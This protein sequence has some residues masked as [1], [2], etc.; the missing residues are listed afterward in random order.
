MPPSEATRLGEPTERTER[1][2]RLDAELAGLDALELARTARRPLPARLWSGGWPK[3]AAVAIGLALWQ[4]VVWSGWKPEFVLPGPAKVWD[5]LFDQAS[6]G[7]LWTALG[8]TAQRAAVGFAMALGAGLA[9]GAVVS[10]VRVLR[11][12]VGSFITGLQT[13]PSIAWFPLSLL[14]FRNSNAAIYFV[15]VLGAAPSVAN[16]LISGVDNLPPLYVRAGRTLGARGVSLFRHVILPGALPSFV[17]GIKQGWAFAWRSLMAGELLVTIAYKHSIGERLEQ[18]R[19]LTDSPT[20]IA[21]MLVILAIGILLDTAVF[22]AAERAVQRR[23]GLTG[24]SR[25]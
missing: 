3:L 15:V 9:V 10:Q 25:G 23:W 19:Q 1:D 14:L 13:M 16:G 12:A 18:A 17:G 2:E 22:G 7:T 8:T 5:A 24:A 20:L 21:Y 4:L 11:L 6:R